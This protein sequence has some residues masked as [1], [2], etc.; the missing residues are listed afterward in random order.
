MATTFKNEIATGFTQVPNTIL[1]DPRISAKAKGIWAYLASKPTGWD[2]SSERIAKEFADGRDSIRAGLR[3]LESVGLLKRTTSNAADGQFTTE[4]EIRIKANHSGKTAAGKSVDGKPDDGKP[5]DK[6]I[7]N[8]EIKNVQIKNKDNIMPA[9]AKPAQARELP[10]EATQLANRLHKWILRNKPDRRIADGWQER[11][12]EDID[13]M[14]RIDGRT[15]QQ[16]AAAIDWSQR[17]E[18]W[19]QNILSGANLR[20]H[21]DRMDDRARSEQDQNQALA[22]AIFNQTPE[23]A[24]ATAKAQGLI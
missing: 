21:Y 2:F 19:H 7:K 1:T 12:A 8:K 16:I 24:I 3:E 23:Q 15:W 13:K 4:Y 5:G 6:V 11:W 14:N 17:D 9:P 22:D 18:F 10:K 20:K